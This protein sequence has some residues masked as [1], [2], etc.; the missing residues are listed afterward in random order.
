MK[1]ESRDS[2]SRRLSP[3]LGGVRRGADRGLDDLLLRHLV[4]LERRDG[5]AAGH[6]DHAVA[7]SLELLRVTRTDDYRH[8]T[9][10]D[11]PQ[12]AVDLGAGADVDALCRLVRN[13][14]RRLG[15]HRAR[16]HDLLLVSAGERGNR[17]LE[18]RRLD[19]KLGQLALDHGHLAPSAHDRADLQPIERRQRGVLAHVQVDHQPFGQPVGRHVR[20]ALEQARCDSSLPGHIDR[21]G[22]LVAP[23]EGAQE[24]A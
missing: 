6:H 16:H 5:V 2:G 3:S 7:Q 14:E 8:A 13:E 12:D 4:T 20:G 18:G 19:G 1:R 23:G 21:S 17:R 11:L 9:T 24:R 10:G 15:E 22:G